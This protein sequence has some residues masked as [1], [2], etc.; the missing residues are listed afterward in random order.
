MAQAFCARGWDLRLERGPEWLFVRPR[1]S[2]EQDASVPS[3][4]EQVWS[5]LE[6]NLT[7]RVVLDLNEIDGLNSLLIEQLLWLHQRAV[8][9]DGLMRIC[10]LSPANQQ[11]LA[12][13][14]LEG[15]FGHFADCEAAVM[16]RD[17]PLQPR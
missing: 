5:L 13:A 6:Q 12:E 7:Y 3:L 1:P 9:H 15:I 17:R 10:G 11:L 16:G 8:A 2:G 4:A 14:G